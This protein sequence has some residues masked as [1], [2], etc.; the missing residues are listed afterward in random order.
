MNLPFFLLKSLTKMSARI[1]AHPENNKHSVF[2]QGLIKLLIMEELN[3]SKKTWQY[4]LVSFNAEIHE[5]QVTEVNTPIE[6]IKTLKNPRNMAIQSSSAEQE[7]ISFTRMTRS[8]ARKIAFEEKGTSKE[9]AESILEQRGS[10]LEVKKVYNRK[11]RRTTMI[12]SINIE[13]VIEKPS[14]STTVRKGIGKSSQKTKKKAPEEYVSR[15]PHT[16]SDK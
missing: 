7:T 6:K 4:F 1:Q 3:K 5:P 9:V 12:D 16:R 11:K 15:K 13:P 10:S 8:V 2:H 14:S